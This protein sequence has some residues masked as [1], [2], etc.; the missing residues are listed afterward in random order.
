[1]PFRNLISALEYEE[2]FNSAI[3][4]WRDRLFGVLLTKRPNLDEIYEKMER[5]KTCLSETNEK[6]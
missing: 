1:M 3:Q 2:G 6:N 4:G 5:N